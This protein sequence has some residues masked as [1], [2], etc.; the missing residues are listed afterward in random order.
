MY[1][2]HAQILKNIGASHTKDLVLDPNFLPK[3]ATTSPEPNVT[4]VN[5]RN[6]KYVNVDRL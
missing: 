4:Y 3:P 2:P 1:L 5:Y 6:I